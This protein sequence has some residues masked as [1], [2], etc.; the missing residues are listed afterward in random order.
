MTCGNCV[1]RVKS[2]LLKLG[3]IIE[4]KVQLAA[5]QAIITMQQHIPIDVLQQAVAKAGS[6]YIITDADSATQHHVASESTASGDSYFPI[7]LIFAYVTGATLLIQFISG[8]FNL[9]QWLSHF[10]AGFFLV[11]SFFKLMN[12]RGFAE[13]YATYDIIAKHLPVYG[14]I[15]PFIELS[16]GVAFL[17]GFMPVLTNVVTLVVMSISAIGVAQSLLKKTP[18]QCAC[19]GTVIKLPLGKVSLLE[20]VL[21]ALMSIAM[22]IAL[23]V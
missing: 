14:R 11:F 23:T 12:L 16:L 17:T 18:F 9:M 19:L 22:I 7:T 3:Y 20:D 15:Y 5:P 6:K 1:A 10:M 2:E 8:G 13:G 21:M 4:V